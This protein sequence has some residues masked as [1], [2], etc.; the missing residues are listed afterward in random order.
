MEQIENIEDLICFLRTKRWND[1]IADD[2]EGFY[3]YLQSKYS[4]RRMWPDKNIKEEFIQY[5]QGIYGIRNKKEKNEE[6]KQKD[7]AFFKEYFGIAETV[8]TTS[9]EPADDKTLVI[10]GGQSGAG[11]SRLIKSA[12]KELNNNAVIVDFD[13]LRKLHP[14]FTPV[15]TNYPEW[16][17]RI[18]H[19]DT[20]EVKNRVL[21]SVMKD[22]YNVIYEGALR[23]TAGFIDFAKKFQ[24][25]DYNIKMKIMAVPKLESY[26]ST[27]FRYAID[28]LSNQTP[29]W[30]EKSAHDGSYEGV[31]RTTDAFINKKL[32]S[33]V[34][35]YVRSSDEPRKIYSTCER[36]Y[37]NAISAIK[38]GREN[39]R[40]QAI[41]DFS[42][43]FQMVEN[44]FRSKRPSMLESLSDWQVLYNQEK[45]YFAN[46][47]KQNEKGI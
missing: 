27:F 26:G 9:K 15:N 45:D 34:S 47:D 3:D 14:N 22:G 2:L 37:P 32:I 39:G 12:N 28:L 4:S 35:V 20:E 44:T 13:E 16:T 5:L 18:L 21:D 46:Y 6:E 25:Y 24:D 36:Q 11:K 29:R 30:V 8:V 31:I 17:H 10:V 7:E 23:N 41:R 43:K 1:T 19:P 33:D 42:D 40:R 38:A